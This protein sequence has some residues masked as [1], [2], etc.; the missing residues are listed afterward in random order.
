MHCLYKSA[1]II[2]YILWFTAIQSI[3]DQMKQLFTSVVRALAATLIVVASGWCVVGCSNDS[4]ERIPTYEVVTVDFEDFITIE[5][6]TQPANPNLV[7]CPSDVDGKIASF[8]ESGTMVKEGEVV[9][10]VE[11]TYA[12]SNFEQWKTNLEQAEA[13]L[14]K[15]EAQLQLDGALLEAKLKNIEAETQLAQLDTVQLAFLTPTA[16]RI[17]ELQIKKNAISREQLLKE[18]NAQEKLQKADILR[19]KNRIKRFTRRYEQARDRRNSL[20]IR[21]PQEGLIMR[22][23]IPYNSTPTPWKIGDNVWS[24]LTLLVYPG[25]KSKVVLHA[26]ETE[27]KRIE[28]GDSVC[29][30]FDAYPGLVAWG[31]I[32]KLAATGKKRT[33]GSGVKTFEVEASVDSTTQALEA[34]M[35]A[36][37]RIYMNHRP[38]TLV[39]PSIAIFDADSSKVVYVHRGKHYEERTV[40]LGLSSQKSTIVENGIREGEKV[41]LIKPDDDLIKTPKRGL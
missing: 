17:K 26:T 18:Y 38:Q 27:F 10:I 12:E 32:T 29:Y 31:K 40:T 13:E 1:Y 25:D 8:V 7:N 33:E 21:A 2:V 15:L 6:E 35:S 16:R 11:D 41:A 9:C 28:E 20:T 14:T 39:V 23:N 24:G 3:Y 5:G 19:V 36:H 34:G 37:C 22:A 4:S 30:T